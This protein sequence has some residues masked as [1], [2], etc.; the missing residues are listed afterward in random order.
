M[1]KK[2]KQRDNQLSTSSA[3]NFTHLCGW[4]SCHGSHKCLCVFL[5]LTP[6]DDWFSSFFLVPKKYGFNLPS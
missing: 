2:A 5:H 1:F 6:L 3:D 4:Y